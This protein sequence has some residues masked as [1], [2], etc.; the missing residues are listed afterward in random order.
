LEIQNSGIENPIKGHFLVVGQTM[1]GKTL[2]TK[3][4]VNAQRNENDIPLL[5]LTTFYQDS[6]WE[7]DLITDDADL[8]YKE[9]LNHTGCNVVIDEAGSF[10]K[11]MSEKGKSLTDFATRGRHFG[12][13]CWFLVQRANMI[14]INARTNCNNL[15]AFQT[16]HYDAK[17]LHQDFVD[18]LILT[19]PTMKPGECVVKLHSTNAYTMNVFTN[20]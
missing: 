11:R 5:V 6:E 8:F 1:S 12:H 14:D 4:L 3:R 2:I 10:V 13:R 9:V 7:A 17:L 18:D 15:I 16:S 19:T 20:P